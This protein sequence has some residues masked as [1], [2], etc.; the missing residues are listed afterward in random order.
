MVQWQPGPRIAVA[1]GLEDT[2][3]G[4]LVEDYAWIFTTQ[5]PQIVWSQPSSEDLDI[6][7][8]Q[9]ISITFN[10][11][12]DHSSTQAALRIQAADGT[13]PPGRLRWNEDSTTMG[14]WPE[15]LLEMDTRYD[16]ELSTQAQSAAGGARLQ[17]GMSTSFWTVE[18]PALLFTSPN[19]GDSSADP[20]GALD[21]YFASPMDTSTLMPNL[22]IIPEPLLC[23]L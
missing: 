19:D 7:L 16:W 17:E 5:A 22:S 10:Q 3:G 6:G 11:P 12:M 15:G 13:V 23:Q 8:T 21:L 18:Y 14:W 20:Y 2:T 9:N 1:A 4:L